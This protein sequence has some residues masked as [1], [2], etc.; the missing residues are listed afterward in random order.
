MSPPS[1]EAL[2]WDIDI[3][4]ATNPVMWGGLVKA[5]LGAA[6]GVA[7]LVGLLLAVQGDW[8]LVLPV[9]GLLLACGAGLLL[10]AGLVMVLV[11]GN[12]LGARFVV[13]AK[14]VRYAQ[15]DR[16]AHA[17]NRAALVLGL[18]L[19]RPA[20]AGS[21]LLA[22]LDEQQTLRWQGAFRAVA[23]PARH[24]I[25]L[26]N[27]W[28]TLLWVYCTPDNFEAVQALLE[29]HMALN[30]TAARAAGPSP[31]RGHLA[32]TALV[33]L[34][35]L[36]LF[37]LAPV[38]GHGL[39][40]PLLL[41]CFALA[42]VWL[43]RPLAWVVLVAAAML[44]VRMLMGA[45]EPRPSSFRAGITDWRFERLSGDDWALTALAA[46]GLVYLVWLAVQTL[47][48]RTLPALEGDLLDGNGP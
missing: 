27:R 6:V 12:R 44:L 32:R 5:V 29:R 34:A 41:M 40:L 10:L 47:R 36:P 30:G 9:A 4:L 48:A 23:H 19:G 39:L 45:V 14:G 26:R 28:R 22:T 16:R 35:C 2:Q 7:A 21:G 15:R 1:N 37:L 13:D 31:L 3:P 17:T 20:A 8:P 42:T 25:A 33:V 24:T 46:L 38:Y 18:L 43:L 11:F